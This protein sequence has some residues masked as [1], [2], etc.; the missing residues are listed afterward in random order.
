MAFLIFLVFL[1]INEK[2]YCIFLTEKIDILHVE[3]CYIGSLILRVGGIG[4]GLGIG[5]SDSVWNPVRFGKQ[6]WP[7]TMLVKVL[8]DYLRYFLSQKCHLA[9]RENLT[10]KGNRRLNTQKFQVPQVR[11][12]WVYN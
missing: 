6:L 1:Q 12:M 5:N 8:C 11:E 7:Q 10:S 9:P 3:S 2:K 4:F